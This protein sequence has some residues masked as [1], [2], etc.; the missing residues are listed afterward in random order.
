VE[1]YAKRFR[2][3][4]PDITGL[5]EDPKRMTIGEGAAKIPG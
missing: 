3:I 2:Q 5:S 4:V 1:G